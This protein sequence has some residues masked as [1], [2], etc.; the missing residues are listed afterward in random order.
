MRTNI[1]TE[2]TLDTVVRIPLRNVNRNTSLFE[3]SRTLRE[4]TVSHVNECRNRERITLLLVA[5]DLDLVYKFLKSLVG[6]LSFWHTHS[7]ILSVLP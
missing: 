5:W 4:C 3:C 2:I 6:A 7:G 1:R